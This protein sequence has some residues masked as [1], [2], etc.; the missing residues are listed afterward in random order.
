MPAQPTKKK[1]SKGSANK[2]EESK[3][4]G[5]KSATG[6]GV[7]R[8]INFEEEDKRL[9]ALGEIQRHLTGHIYERTNGKV[10][11]PSQ[12]LRKNYFWH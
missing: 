8:R 5:T 12:I 1:A 4:T 2:N 11:D 3:G 10:W 6:A 9:A 7:S